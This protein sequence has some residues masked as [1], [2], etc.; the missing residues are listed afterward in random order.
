MINVV[1]HRGSLSN[2]H[3]S[4]AAG[5]EPSIAQTT[6]R[7]ACPATISPRCLPLPK[8]AFDMGVAFR[9]GSAR[10]GTRICRGNLCGLSASGLIGPVLAGLIRQVVGPLPFAQP[11]DYSLLLF[12]P[13]S[14]RRFPGALAA[15]RIGRDF[16]NRW[17]ILPTTRRR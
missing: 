2:R 11:T 17:P 16:R 15:R 10:R 5:V 1:R 8:Q 6:P 9:I 7:A 13:S 3:D 4:R 12:D 14:Q